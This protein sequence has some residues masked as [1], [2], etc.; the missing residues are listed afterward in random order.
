MR[1]ILF[2]ITFVL[3]MFAFASPVSPPAAV[4]PDH[5]FVQPDL[6]SV[7]S[8][9]ELNSVEM[10]IPTNFIRDVSVV[11]IETFE[12][13]EQSVD[14]NLNYTKED[15]GERST[16]L[17]LLQIANKASSNY[18]SNASPPIK[19]SGITIVDIVLTC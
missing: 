17:T 10:F 14:Q 19:Q 5:S 3:A 9:N 11:Q 7:G 13:S 16:Q 18:R 12:A 4:I 1:T 8:L 6:L 15:Y 2:A